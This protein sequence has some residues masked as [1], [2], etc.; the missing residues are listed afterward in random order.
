[1]QNLWHLP[2]LQSTSFDVFLHQIFFVTM[3]FV[4]QIHVSLSHLLAPEVMTLL[5]DF[6][7]P[8]FQP[9]SVKQLQ[10]SIPSPALFFVLQAVLR[11]RSYLWFLFPFAVSAVQVVANV[12]T[13]F[14]LSL[15][16][17][18][19][20]TLAINVPF[21]GIL[22]FQE[23]FWLLFSLQKCPLERCNLLIFFVE[24]WN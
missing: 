15:H 23:T 8:F 7:V 19:D 24:I 1:M 9:F 17:I 12:I 5:L 16:L 22:P 21:L 13:Q 20:L 6:V 4:S 14:G 11:C 10:A 3:K 2:L 18:I